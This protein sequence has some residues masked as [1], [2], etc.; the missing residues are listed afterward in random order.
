MQNIPIPERPHLIPI[1]FGESDFYEGDFAQANC[2]MQ[3]GDRPVNMT[4][5]FNGFVLQS[6]GGIEIEYTGRSSFLTLDPVRGDHQG[7]YTCKAS[8][9]AGEEQV[10]ATLTVN[11]I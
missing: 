9:Q 3:K 8:N 2:V 1:D 7:L 5:I 10:S 6:R 4:W 11:G